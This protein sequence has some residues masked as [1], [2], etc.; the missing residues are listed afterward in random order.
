M[1][2]LEK[3]LVIKTHNRIFGLDVL[4]CIAIILVVA[5]HGRYLVADTFLYEFP[6]INF[7][8]GVDLFFVLSGFLIGSLLLKDITKENKFS[9]YQLVNFWKRRWFRTL[10]N[11]YLILLVNFI[12]VKCGLIGGDINYVNWKFVFFLQNFTHSF[13]WFFLESWSLTIEEWF[14]IF[15]PLILILLLKFFKPK[16]AFLLTV[17]ILLLFPLLYRVYTACYAGLPESD[18]YENIKKVVL[19]RLDAIGYGLLAAWFAFYYKDLWQKYKIAFAILGAVVLYIIAHDMFNSSFL[20]RNVFLYS[21][22]PF[23]LML[24]L[25][26]AYSIKTGY[27]FAG[28]CVT[29]ISKISYSMYLV[30]LAIVAG[31]IRHNFPVEN[32]TDGVIKYFIY[33]MIV[34]ILSSIIYRFYEKPMMDLRDKFR[35][36]KR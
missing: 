23:A 6:Y 18:L 28:K 9:S 32:I 26:M 12:I 30:N 31:V 29:H 14:Y 24:F 25:P 4:R 2:A 10:P 33:W 5:I 1:L 17:L 8:D 11:Y 16:N 3:N 19:T 22:S 20:Y 7:V 36:R 13:G 27:G 15:T 34:I 35:V 21:F